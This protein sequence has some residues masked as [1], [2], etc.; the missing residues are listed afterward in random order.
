MKTLP[1]VDQILRF[2]NDAAKAEFNEHPAR[3]RPIIRS[4]NNVEVVQVVNI[5]Y[6]VIAE[7][8]DNQVAE[9]RID[10]RYTI[11]ILFSELKYFEIDK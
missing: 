6:D 1:K 7:R 8:G 5:P 4:D 10:G 3:G 9:I 2:K 11:R